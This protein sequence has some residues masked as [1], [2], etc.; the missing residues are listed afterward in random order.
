MLVGDQRHT[1]GTRHDGDFAQVDAA[2]DDNQPHAEPED[3]EDGNA[4]DQTEDVRGGGESGKAKANSSNRIITMAATTC[5]WLSW[6]N[7]RHGTG[8][9]GFAVV[10][11]AIAGPF[12]LSSMDRSS[13]EWPRT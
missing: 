8:L 13:S 9:S 6:L 7:P 12:F 4:A 5:S 3:A 10:K 2:A 1:P 11:V